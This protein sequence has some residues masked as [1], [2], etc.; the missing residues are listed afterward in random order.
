MESS[1][2]RHDT[3]PR[4]GRPRHMTCRNQNPQAGNQR[5]EPPAY[6]GSASREQPSQEKQHPSAGSNRNGRRGGPRRRRS[7]R[8]SLAALCRAQIRAPRPAW[9]RVRTEGTATGPRARA[10]PGR[11]GRQGARGSLSSEFVINRVSGSGRSQQPGACHISTCSAPLTH[12][13][14]GLVGACVYV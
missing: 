12:M 4:R 10:G 13:G 1:T 5:I 3:G 14:V 7:W 2:G 8:S 11:A 6:Q 9:T